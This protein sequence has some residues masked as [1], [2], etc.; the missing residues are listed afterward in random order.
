MAVLCNHV[1]K[2]GLPPVFIMGVRVPSFW[3]LPRLVFSQVSIV[4]PVYAGRSMDLDAEVHEGWWAG[5]QPTAAYALHGF[6]GDV[7]FCARI[8]ILMPFLNGSESVAPLR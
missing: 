8:A 7:W 5:G 6:P 3:K 4:Q 2:V 1:L